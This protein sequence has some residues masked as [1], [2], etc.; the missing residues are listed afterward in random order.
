MFTVQE[1][2]RVHRYQPLI[3]WKYIASPIN[4]FFHNLWRHKFIFTSSSKIMG[5]RGRDFLGT[6]YVPQERNLAVR[7]FDGFDWEPCVYLLKWRM[8]RVDDKEE[9]I[10]LLSFHIICQSFSNNCQSKL[11]ECSNNGLCCIQIIVKDRKKSIVRRD[12]S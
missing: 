8:G 6:F 1:S 4:F 11:L 2:S 12:V 3:Y 10:P 9:L 5:C 7:Y